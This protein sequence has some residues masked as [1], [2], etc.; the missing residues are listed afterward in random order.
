MRK[1]TIAVTLIGLLLLMS[2]CQGSTGPA[3]SDADAA[4]SKKPVDITFWY[5]YGDTVG[6][7]NEALVKQF[8]ES[9]N[10]V[11][12]SAQFQGA[13]YNTLQ[14]KLQ[15]AIAARNGPDVTVIENLA[16]GPFANAGV[17]QDLSGL[18]EQEHDD[19]S[20]F[21]P[22]MLGNSYFNNKLYALPYMR[23]TNILYL[24]L[25]M[26]KAAGLDPAGPKTWDELAEY[27]RKL[28]DP[29]HHYGI[30]TPLDYTRFE[31]F[32]KEA[33]GDILSKDGTKAIFNSPQGVEALDFWRKLHQDGVADL[34]Y[35]DK[36]GEVALQN[37]SNQKAAMTIV[38]TAYITSFA[39]AAKQN[40]FELGAVV[41]P[42]KV[43]SESTG[44]G[45][46][47]AMLANLTPEK[48]AAAWKFL[49]W[50]TNTEQTATTSIMTG[51]LPTRHSA[52]NGSRMQA[53]FQQNA[54]FKVASDQTQMAGP[55]PMSLAY[56]EIGKILTTQLEKSMLDPSYSART[57]LD[58][59]A[60][61]ANVL[62]NK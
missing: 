55:R 57:A 7:T 36:M 2:A 23:S 27:A 12:V 6:K 50:M 21:I 48:Q 54:V 28:N 35:G 44:L 33:G 32:I 26:L 47:L 59:A 31:S 13:D 18:A 60:K 62:L 24:N 17:L 34:P 61:Q 8:N 58:E 25:T 19:M 53:V 20:D 56:Y 1:L 9:Q 49:K 42:K 37:F 10:E 43:N 51:Y 16:T 40:G 5:A 41:M 15:A 52:I 22:L 30:T 4:A 29:G 3:G 11:K 46:N 39:A 38:S 45:S 14:A